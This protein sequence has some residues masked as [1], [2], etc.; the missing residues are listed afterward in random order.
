MGFLYQFFPSI[1][2]VIF[3]TISYMAERIVGQGSFG[4]VFQV[5]IYCNV[6]PW[7]QLGNSIQ[8]I[9]IGLTY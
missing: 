9:N 8:R 1:V 5:I 2:D 6:V 3:Q 4:V 7:K